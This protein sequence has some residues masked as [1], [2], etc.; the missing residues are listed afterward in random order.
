MGTPGHIAWHSSDNDVA[1]VTGG[2]VR[3][4]SAGQATITAYWS[5]YRASALVT[6]PG[7][8]KK[9]QDAIACLEREHDSA[10]QLMSKC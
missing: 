8:A 4:V 7:P 2:V 1:T 6:V 5:G 3:A 10:Q 9:H